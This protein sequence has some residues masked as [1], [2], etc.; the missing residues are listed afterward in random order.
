M[1]DIAIGH[2]L[3]TFTYI[4]GDFASVSANAAVLRPVA[5]LLDSDGKPTGKTIDVTAADHVAFSGRL[6]SGAFTSITWRA[7]YAS[8]KGRRQLLWEIDGEE[9]SIRFDEEAQS[10]AFM[11]VREPKLYLNG[12]L[13]EVES[14]GGLP[15]LLG[16]AWAEFAKG[17]VG[18][19]A[20]IEDAVRNHRL[21]DAIK[22]SIDSEGKT[23][24]L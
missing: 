5:A 6:K 11:N 8:T 9:G 22:R 15:G 19:Y 13:V 14:V 3:D 17:G 10:A 21:L 20:T 7:G 23:V 2:Q 1:I 18:Q 4:L 24:V 12:E 16:I